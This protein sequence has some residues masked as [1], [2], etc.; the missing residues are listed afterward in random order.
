M[1]YVS[2]WEEMLVGLSR[3]CLVEVDEIR[4]AQIGQ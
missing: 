4:N 1:D 2:W 3:L